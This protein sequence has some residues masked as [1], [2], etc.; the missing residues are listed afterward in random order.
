MLHLTKHPARAFLVSA[1]FSASL[2]LGCQPA[3]DDNAHPPTNEEAHIEDDHIENHHN[4]QEHNHD[5]D[6]HDMHEH[7]EHTDDH[8]DEHGHEMDTHHDEH[9]AHD[10]SHHDHN[11]DAH[12]IQYNCDPKQS[13]GVAYH[14]N[15]TPATAHLLIEGIEYDLALSDKNTYR[16][17]YGIN[18]NHGL[19]WQ[20]DETHNKATLLETKTNSS[21]EPSALYR[22]QKD[23]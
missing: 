21:E 12:R 14:T 16:S 20:V 10:H 19:I 3:N 11:H 9:A 1:I 7:D 15:D 2:L 4:H 22:C 17:D 8:A 13:I 18:E 6:E 23:V 5:S